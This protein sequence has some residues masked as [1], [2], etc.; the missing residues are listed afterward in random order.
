MSLFSGPY[1]AYGCILTTLLQWGCQPIHLAMMFF[2][3]IEN[4]IQKYN[5][6]FTG[7]KFGKVRSVNRQSNFI[8]KSTVIDFIYFFIRFGSVR[9]MLDIRQ[10][11]NDLVI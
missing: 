8:C 6:Q 10:R 1:L 7:F 11:Q 4:V 5:K 3:L 9:G 2:N